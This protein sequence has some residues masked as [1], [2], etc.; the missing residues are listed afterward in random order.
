MNVDIRVSRC[1]VTRMIVRPDPLAF[2]YTL[3]LM[4]DILELNVRFLVHACPI[5]ICLY[6]SII[7]T[8]YSLR[9]Q[10]FSPLI[11]FESRYIENA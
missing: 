3:L 4:L 8:I 10:K 5:T 6:T 11:L 9:L 7:K 2:L 1:V